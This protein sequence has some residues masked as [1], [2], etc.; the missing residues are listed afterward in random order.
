MLEIDCVTS[1]S[2]LD[3][4]IVECPQHDPKLPER[5]YCS[6]AAI[7]PGLSGSESRLLAPMLSSDAAVYKMIGMA[8]LISAIPLQF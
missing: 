8:E 3:L 4:S 6:M 5:F 1:A 7:P 2:F